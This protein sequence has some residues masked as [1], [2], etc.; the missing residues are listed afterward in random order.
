[1]KKF[2]E[3][4]VNDWSNYDSATPDCLRSFATGRGFSLQRR[5]T[6]TEE[7]H[8][9]NMSKKRKKVP[10]E[11]GEMVLLARREIDALA[12]GEGEEVSVKYLAEAFP[13]R[14]L[15]AI[16]EVRKRPAYKELLV[17]NSKLVC[18]HCH[19]KD[20]LWG[21]KPN[22]GTGPMCPGPL[23]GGNKAECQE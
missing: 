22:N 14:T 18:H 10:W 12:A 6:H 13:N 19:L 5:S 1:M 17:T 20:S 7:H 2:E 16:K 11:H 8:L 21:Q 15:K 23:A 4:Q 9:E 3:A